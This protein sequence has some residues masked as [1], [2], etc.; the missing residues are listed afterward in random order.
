MTKMLQVI[1]K[2]I[3]PATVGVIG[4]MIISAIF[5]NA[6]GQVTDSAFANCVMISGGFTVD[7]VMLG[8]DDDCDAGLF[9][10]AVKYYKAQGYTERQYS[11]IFGEQI[12]S[13]EK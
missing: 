11:N 9:E 4:I 2:T 5:G 12:M 13:L 7:V 3:L 6:F 8:T 1:M 10:Q